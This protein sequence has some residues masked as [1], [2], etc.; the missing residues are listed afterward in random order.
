[1]S[2]IAAEHHPGILEKNQTI[3]TQKLYINGPDLSDASVDRTFFGPGGDLVAEGAK[4]PLRHEQIWTLDEE[5]K[6]ERIWEK[7]EP[8]WREEKLK[9]KPSLFRA[10][11]RTFKHH[12]LGSFGIMWGYAAMSFVNPI[13]L[14]FLIQYVNDFNYPTYSGFIYIFCIIIAQLAGSVFYYYGSFRANI[15]GMNMRTALLLLVYRKSLEIAPSKDSNSG[16]IV[17]MVS[18]D[19]LFIADSVSIVAAGVSVPL[20]LIIS[21]VLLGIYVNYFVVILLGIMFLSLPLM[22][23]LGMADRKSVV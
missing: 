14:P 11:F 22:G 19:A 21:F 12:I 5:N 4:A 3:E 23:K 15:A 17:N 16:Q 1:M 7:L 6:A 9:A 2:V 10:V 13:I 20:Q 18:S 8:F